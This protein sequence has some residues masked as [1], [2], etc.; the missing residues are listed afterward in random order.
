MITR[1]D[2]HL[3]KVA[4]LYHEVLDDPVEGAAL[5]SNGVPAFAARDATAD[6]R[7][8]PASSRAPSFFYFETRNSC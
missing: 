4:T 1:L 3:Y 2:A 8:H 5:V 7:S 6:V